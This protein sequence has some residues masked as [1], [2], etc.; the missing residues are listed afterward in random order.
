MSA[1]D[2]IALAGAIGQLGEQVEAIDPDEQGPFPF[3][4]LFDRL[5]ELRAAFR[6]VQF[7]DRARQQELWGSLQPLGDRLAKARARYR[8]NCESDQAK[9]TAAVRD[10]D[11]SLDCATNGHATWGAFW[12]E[13]RDVRELLRTSRFVSRE[14]REAAWTA[15]NRIVGKAEAD[16]E[17]K[18]RQRWHFEQDSEEHRKQILFHV[19]QARPVV[20]LIADLLTLD[21]LND[22]H[23]ELKTW[24]N[25]L[26]RARDEL[27]DR[28][29]EMTGRHRHEVRETI[30]EVQEDLNAAWNDWKDRKQ[31]DRDRRAEEWRER[32]THRRD[33]LE[34]IITRKEEFIARQEE[35]L[36]KLNNMLANARNDERAEQIETWIEGANERRDNAERELRELEEQLEEVNDKLRGR[37]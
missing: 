9:T 28:S 10:L 20:G 18:Q 32:M 25:E 11:C 27:H 3:G 5:G 13:V 7:T 26:R 30:A 2:E 1:W 19:S 31:E 24:S 35:N 36:E 21:W 33:K 29:E 14:A 6:G 23:E 8:A 37:D 12:A 17:K 16:H 22:R 34:D 4:K 15:L